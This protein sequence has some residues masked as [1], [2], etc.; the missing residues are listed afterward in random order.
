MPLPTTFDFSVIMI[1]GA[2]EINSGGV[3]V[4]FLAGE[5]LFHDYADV[6]LTFPVGF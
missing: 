4:V 3:G 1:A 2:K 6:L 5:G